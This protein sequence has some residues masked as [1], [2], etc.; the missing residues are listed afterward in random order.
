MKATLT[1]LLPDHQAEF[2]NCAKGVDWLCF[3]IDL[4]RKVRDKL[5]YEEIT[6]EQRA[7]LEHVRDWIIAGL[8][9]RGL[10]LYPSQTFNN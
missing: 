10:R 9:E 3:A 1:F 5:K 8:D 7:T 4:D 6:A 2:E